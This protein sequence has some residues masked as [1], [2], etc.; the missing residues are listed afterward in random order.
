MRTLAHKQNQP[1]QRVSSSLARS[2]TTISGPNHHTNP[3]LHSQ[4][5]ISN[6]AKLAINIKGD[7]REQVAG[8]REEMRSISISP[9]VAPTLRF[10]FARIPVTAPAIQR[11]PTISSPGDPFER[12][13]DDV[14]DRII[15]MAE[16]P[17][18]N[19]V[20]PTIQ[21]KC[22]ECEDEEKTIQTK[23]SAHIGA[24]LDAGAAVRATEQ[25][26]IP[27]SRE[28]R[29]YFEPRF[30]HDFSRVRVHADGGAADGARA[31]RARAYTLGR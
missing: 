13:A 30:G 25:G 10:D 31:V 14:A 28:V 7:E 23:P 22:A 17:S 4:R 8:A 16:P 6:Q 3:I 1:Q 9:P 15:R 18:G 12:E 27:L 2:S 11:K 26:G 29:S 20:P 5:P 21:R 19:P 24:A